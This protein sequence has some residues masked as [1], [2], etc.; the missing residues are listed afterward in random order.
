M[1]VPRDVAMAPAKRRLEQLRTIHEVSK[2]IAAVL[3]LEDLLPFVV[4]AVRDAFRYQNVNIF[5]VDGDGAEL[6]LRAGAGGFDG[7]VPVGTRL[8]IGTQG[9][10]GHVGATREPYLVNDV[11]REPRYYLLDALRSAR[12]ELAVPIKLGDRLLGV[13]DVESRELNAFGEDDVFVMQTLADMVAVAVENARLYEQSREIAVLEERNRLAREIHDTIA[14]GLAGIIL[15][16]EAADQHFEAG[17]L[18][19][20][21]LRVVKAAE[22]ARQHLQDARRSVWNLRPAPLE[23][24]S[25]AEAFDAEVRRLADQMDVDA[26]Y[27]LSG[28]LRPLPPEV[29]NCLYR[30]LQ[31]SLANVRKH[32]GAR[33]VKVRLSYGPDAVTLLIDD[34]GHGFDPAA[35]RPTNGGF[36]LLGMQERVRLVGGRLSVR[37]QPG[38]GTEVKVRIPY[39]A[40]SGGGGHG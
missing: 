36:G 31:E 40:R 38:R 35:P 25:L 2:R 14:Q 22:L 30:I 5:L 29:E 9:I 20:A 27:Q 23:G 4:N 1:T 33:Q 18:D 24:H 6:V 28:Q 15:Q 21:R 32:S 8:R 19:R 13:L 37:S 11:E 3:A 16:L 39:S 17:Q 12:A 26:R 34:D 7:E 10:V